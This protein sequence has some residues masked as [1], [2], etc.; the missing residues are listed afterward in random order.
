MPLPLIAMAAG[1][2]IGAASKFI[3]AAKQ[4]KLAKA[5]NPINQTYTED[6]NVS[7][8]FGQ[9]KNL[10]QG[11]MAGATQAEQGISTGEANATA[12]AE[13]NATDASQLLSFGAANYG[14]GNDARIDLATKEA[15]DKQNRFGIYSNV[16]QLMNQERDKTFQDKL[17]KYYDDLNY[18][19][20]LEGAAMQN[21]AGAWN[22]I[23][24]GL[25]SIGTSGLLGGGVGK[26]RGGI[27]AAGVQNA[28]A[29]GMYN[30]GFNPYQG[31]S[32]AATFGQ[33]PYTPAQ[34]NRINGLSQYLNRP[35]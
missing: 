34:P 5:I 26:A 3:A 6:P 22:G 18:K 12:F 21:N 19:R 31:A 17:R 29:Q 2:A 35:R 16:T 20:G 24:E 13:R 33:I 32:P 27:S 28:P 23:S 9:G 1:A 25:M 8:L 10:Y 15:Q 11:R 7:G 14:Q 30:R 4:K